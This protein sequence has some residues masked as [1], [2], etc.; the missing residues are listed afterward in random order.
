MKLKA[1]H[2][3]VVVCSASRAEQHLR[4]TKHSTGKPV[5]ALV[6]IASAP[7]YG[8]GKQRPS[9]TAS[10]VA[11]RKL[12]LEFDDAIPHW[13][14]SI[15]Q[16]EAL[17]TEEDVRKILSFGSVFPH[18]SRVDEPQSSRV[19]IHCL[20]GHSRST[21]AALMLFAQ[22]MKTAT[23]DEIIATFTSACEEGQQ[24]KPNTW[25]VNLA[26]QALGFYGRL[27]YI[28]ELLTVAHSPGM[29]G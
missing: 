13:N 24:V 9:G 21:A 19:I 11:G 7:T 23:D 29:Y 14:K 16:R 18:F 15:K 22:Q 4:N 25:M 8:L 12:F 2:P 3:N 26:D 20:A 6:S 28:N 10:L 17:P 27:N 5:A 1:L